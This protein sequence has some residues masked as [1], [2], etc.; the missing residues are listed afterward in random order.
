[1]SKVCDTEFERKIK[2]LSDWLEEHFNFDDKG[3]K[4]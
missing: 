1:V 3:K 4:I 2:E